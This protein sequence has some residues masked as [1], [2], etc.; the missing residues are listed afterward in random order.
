MVLDRPSPDSCLL[1]SC[2]G[3]REHADT[4]S[5]ESHALGLMREIDKIALQQRR[6]EDR[7]IPGSN[8]F[9]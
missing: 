6:H 3:H 4:A 7:S 5:F 8:Q 2:V 9:D 1:E